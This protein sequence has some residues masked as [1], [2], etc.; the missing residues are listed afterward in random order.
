MKIFAHYDSTGAIQSLVVVNAPEGH[1]PMLAPKPGL[2][3]A[4]VEGLKLKS[5]T[6]DVE[7]LREIARTHKVASPSPRCTLVKKKG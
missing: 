3:V 1:G 5:E 2:F 6:P 7:T 4:E